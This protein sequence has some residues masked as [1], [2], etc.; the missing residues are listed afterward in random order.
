[1]T[2]QAK[3]T[4]TVSINRKLNLGDYESIDVFTSLSGVYDGMPEEEMLAALKAGAVAYEL[5]REQLITQLKEIRRSTGT[6]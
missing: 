5:V 3:P 4:V 1:M 6:G 2:E